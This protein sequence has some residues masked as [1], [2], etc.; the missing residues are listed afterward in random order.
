[1][2]AGLEKEI[3]RGVRLHDF[4]YVGRDLCCE[5]VRVRDIVQAAGT[6]VYIYSHRMMV[7]HLR[8]LQRAF[9]SLRPLIC[10]SMKANS[11]LAVLKALVRE[12]AGLDIV[13]GGELYRA[14]RAGCEARKIV[15]AGVGKTGEEIEE[16]IRAGILLFNVE[17]TAELGEINRIA[18]RLKKKV[19]VSLRVNPGVDP[20]THRHIATGKPESK[21]G[22]D[23]D[24]A[25]AVF[26]KSPGYP[27]LSI[28]GIHVHIGS[29]ILTGEPFLKAFRKV[30]IFITSLEN[31]GCKIEYLNLGGGLGIIYSDERPQTA[32]E[33]AKEILP[34]FHA[35]K[36][37][38]IFEPGRFIVGN[39]GILAARVLYLKKTPMK[40]FAVLDTG[41]NDLIRPTLYDSHHEVWPLEKDPQREKRVYDF[42]G[43]VCESGDFLARDRSTQELRAGEALAFLSA[44]AYGFSMAS[45][46]NSRPRPAEVLVKGSEFA[47][48]RKRETCEDLVRG[49]KIPAFLR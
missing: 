12:G 3:E 18:G 32:E 1:M 6:P 47:V 35:R 27:A 13:S 44:G 42:V 26:I 10:Y 2:S 34:L 16:A 29:Q 15:Y 39:A 38:L 36:F 19:K 48:I 46:Y 9:R 49:E 7:E 33:F 17:S 31:E 40:N 20:G 8:K 37:R 45:S 5:K 25:H 4:Y 23:L 30:L 43:P 41:M 22:L 11:N 24:T 21:F 28:C 14:R